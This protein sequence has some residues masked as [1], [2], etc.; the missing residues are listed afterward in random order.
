MSSIHRFYKISKC[1]AK[2]R[3]VIICICVFLALS[4]T[5]YCI[6]CE[7]W[8]CSVAYKSLSIY[9]I[10]LFQAKEDSVLKNMLATYTYTKAQ[11]AQIEK[12]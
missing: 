5:F 3:T 9:L 1:Q 11:N 10:Q 8:G 6:F 2:I 7:N 4:S 12:I